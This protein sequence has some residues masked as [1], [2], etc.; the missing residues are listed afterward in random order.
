[1][2]SSGAVGSRKLLPPAT[3]RG[4]PVARNP[5]LKVKPDSKTWVLCFSPEFCAGAS[6]KVMDLF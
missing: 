3:S 5:A 2:D 6:G 1:M 4:S